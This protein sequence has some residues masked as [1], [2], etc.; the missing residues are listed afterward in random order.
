MGCK[1]RT[2]NI[3]QKRGDNKYK[4]GNVNEKG[5]YFSSNNN[6]YYI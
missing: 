2:R 5:N 3:V 6:Y 1:G 4:E